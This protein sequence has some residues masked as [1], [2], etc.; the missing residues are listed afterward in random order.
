MPPV[1]ISGSHIKT[2]QNSLLS[3]STTAL[4]LTPVVEA[5]HKSKNK[6]KNPLPLGYGLGWFVREEKEGLFT[7]KRHPFYFGHSGG[8]VGASSILLVMPS[9]EKEGETN[10]TIGIQET[11][12]VCST[13]KC[14]IK[15]SRCCFKEKLFDIRV[16]TKS[17]L[18]KSTI[19]TGYS[20]SIAS[21][22]LFKK[23]RGVAGLKSG[24]VETLKP[25]P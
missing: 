7:G 9:R 5:V 12:K 3:H 6:L 19:D 21:C 23:I 13:V 10:Q 18:I 17:F 1:L 15:C 22:M 14:I 4:M 2:P 25:D 8:A 24:Q 16:D 20:Q 11:S